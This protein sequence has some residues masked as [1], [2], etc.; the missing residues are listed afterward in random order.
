MLLQQKGYELPNRNGG[1]E[2][3]EAGWTQCGSLVETS[4]WVSIFPRSPR[5][6]GSQHAVS[7]DIFMT[8]NVLQCME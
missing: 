2:A 3:R 5:L 8:K 4:P 7:R 1:D 6:T